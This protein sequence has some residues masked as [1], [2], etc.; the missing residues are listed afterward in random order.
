MGNFNLQQQRYGN[1]W[2]HIS[3]KHSPD[4]KIYRVWQRQIPWKV[5]SSRMGKAKWACAIFI[6]NQGGASEM[7]WEND[8]YSSIRGKRAERSIEY[9]HNWTLPKD[10]KGTRIKEIKHKIS[11]AR[12]ELR[13]SDNRKS[14]RRRDLSKEISD[15][16]KWRNATRLNMPCDTTT[17][18][19]I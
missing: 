17:W 11:A 14:K 13:R 5:L 3:E 2:R 4:Y 10:T 15:R 6:W 16:A 18:N 7:K 8:I 1:W 9:G 19:D 12:I